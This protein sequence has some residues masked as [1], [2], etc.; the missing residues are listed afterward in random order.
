MLAVSATLATGATS[1]ASPAPR[2]STGAA[3]AGTTAVGSRTVDSTALDNTALDSTALDNRAIGS[4]A[5]ESTFKLADPDTV[6]ANTG[7]F[8]TYGTSRGNA[9]MCDGATRGLKVPYLVHGHG[10]RVGMSN[11]AKGDALPRRNLP[12]WVNKN[13]GIWA[14]GVVKYNGK[15]LMYYTAQKAGT[16]Q[17]CVGLAWAKGARSEFRP[18]GETLRKAKRQDHPWACPRSGR[19]VIDANPY[20]AG[21]RLYVTYRD[22]AVTRGKETGISAVRAGKHGW[23]RKG[24][25]GRRTVITSKDIDWDTKGTGPEHSHVIENPAMFKWNGRWFIAYSA[26]RWQ[27]A[28]YSTGIARCGTNPIPQNGC[29]PMRRGVQRPYFGF[30]GKAGINPWR[31]LPGNHAG[32]GGMDVFKTADGSNHVVWHWLKRKN[33]TRRP[34]TGDLVWRDGGFRVR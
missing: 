3:Q 22:D 19:W 31:G 5:T 21:G 23:A 4:T 15:Y 16:G 6:R 13:K 11:C 30:K 18:Y 29:A 34:I 33:G 17:R 7:H 10:K 9:K 32:P 2:A 24:F 20:V 14:P 12:N 26:N 28:R 27:T 1:A 25:A 8:I